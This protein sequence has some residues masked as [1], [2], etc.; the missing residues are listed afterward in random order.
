MAET[1]EMSSWLPRTTTEAVF[2]RKIGA[3]SWRAVGPR[4]ADAG[5]D[6]VA[7]VQ[8]CFVHAFVA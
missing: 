4:M 5:Q 2:V 7:K 6:K 8:Q 3:V 1:D